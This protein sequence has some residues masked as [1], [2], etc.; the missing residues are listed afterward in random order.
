M[1]KT[2]GFIETH[3]H[4]AF[5]VNF[6]NCDVDDII[7]VAVKIAKLGVTRIYPTLMTA[8]V[9]QIKEQIEKV[10]SAQKKQPADSALIGGVHLEGPFINPFKKGIHQEKYIL[11]PTISNYKK[12]DDDIIKIVTISPELDNN[13]ALC[14]YLHSRAVFVQ[15]GH[16]MTYNLSECDSVTHLFNAMP[17][18]THK[19]QNIISSALSD[20]NM[21]VEMIAD[22]NHVIDDVLKTVFKTKPHD[23]IILISDALPMTHGGKDECEFAGQTVNYNNGSFYNTDGVLAGSGMLQPD[24]LKRLLK[25]NILTFEDAAFMMNITPAKYLKVLN[26]A[27]VTFDDD[28]NPIKTDFIH[29][30]N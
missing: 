10:K 3:F 18:L 24:I 21:F 30:K 12:L 23:K 16:T 15:A 22:G 28:L 13:R 7:E 19:F 5:G 6:M 17:P 26:N 9:G 20:D 11:E 8:P 2:E 1:Y 25:A 29:H 4:G 27:F 14:K